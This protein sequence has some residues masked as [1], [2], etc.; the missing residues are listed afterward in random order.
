MAVGVSVATAVL[1]WSLQAVHAQLGRE[2]TPFNRVLTTGSGIAGMFWGPTAFG[3]AGHRRT[4]SASGRHHQLCERVLPDVLDFGREPAAG[5]SDAEAAAASP[6]RRAGNRGGIGRDSAEC[7]ARHAHPHEKARDL[8]SRR[9]RAGAARS[10]ARDPRRGGP[11]R[12]VAALGGASR[13]RI[14]C[15]ALPALREPRGA[16]GRCG[17]RGICR[18]ARGAAPCRRG[19]RE[20]ARTHRPHR[21]RLCAVRGATR[22]ACCA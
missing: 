14:A 15:R 6:C 7:C 22:R 10:R 19:T 17:D 4:D 12:A 16:P 18:I 5:P 9:P 13:R 20:R 21:C 11:G 1:I 3:A 2:R 8:S